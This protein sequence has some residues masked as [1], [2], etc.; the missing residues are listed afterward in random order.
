MRIGRF[1]AMHKSRFQDQKAFFVKLLSASG[2]DDCRVNSV[3]GGVPA[4][5]HDV[6][7]IVP[8]CAAEEK[9]ICVRDLA[10]EYGMTS[11]EMLMRLRAM[12]VP[13]NSLSAFLTKTQEV[14]VRGR[15]ESRWIRPR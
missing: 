6:V 12:G 11:T 2:I 7:E 14:L 13:V 5:I 1:Q 3:A 4:C 10:R 15:L 9:T 8:P